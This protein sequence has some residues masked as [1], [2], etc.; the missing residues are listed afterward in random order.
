MKLITLNTWGGQ[1]FE[2]LAEFLKR[3]STEIDIFC[4]QEVLHNAVNVR[5]VLG[6]V[7]P[8]LFS[9]FEQMLGERFA[10]SYAA[11]QDNDEGLAMFVQKTIRIEEQGDIF[12]YKHKNA[13]IGDDGTTVGRNIQYVSFTQNNKQYT[14]VNFHG[15]WTGGDKKDTPERFEQSK[16]VKR[17][18]ND[19]PG[20]KV[21]CGDFNLLPDT[22]SVAILEKGM[23]NLIKEHGI[24]S[25]RSHFYDKEPKFADYIMVS[26]EI[27]VKD[28]RVLQDPVSDHLP[29]YL[30]FSID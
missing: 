26:P 18:L 24:T 22:E 8:N 1:V 9:E 11:S 27:K 16:K 3:Y 23:R 17:F 30:D 28:F 10:G 25:T 7:R 15:L 4:F 19:A 14:V 12:V 29:L 5:P 6:D 13:M 21:L 2:P 20:A